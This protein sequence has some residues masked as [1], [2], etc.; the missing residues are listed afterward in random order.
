MNCIFPTQQFLIMKYDKANSIKQLFRL[1]RVVQS[2]DFW[3]FKRQT[4]SWWQTEACSQVS[5]PS[6][7]S[8]ISCPSIHPP[9]IPCPSFLPFI[10]PSIHS[11]SQCPTAQPSTLLSIHPFT[12]VS[13]HYPLSQPASQPASQKTFIQSKLGSG[14]LCSSWGNRKNKME[15]MCAVGF[16]IHW[17][18]SKCLGLVL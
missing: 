2:A 7:H 15:L 16:M 1:F 10:Y 17:E 14:A 18:T 6:V 9:R 13:I 3:P 8:S 11:S 4:A 5:C 12:L